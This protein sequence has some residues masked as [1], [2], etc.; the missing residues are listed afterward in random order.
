MD[1]LFNINRWYLIYV[2]EEK[3]P[4]HL[5]IQTYLLNGL[6][7][8]VYNLCLTKPQSLLSHLAEKMLMMKEDMR[9]NLLHFTDTDISAKETLVFALFTKYRRHAVA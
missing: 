9:R 8:Q 6:S 1:E 3:H 5:K 7:D 4:V 2:L